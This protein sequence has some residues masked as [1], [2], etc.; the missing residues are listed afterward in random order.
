MPTPKKPAKKPAA[1]AKKPTTAKKAAPAKKPAAPARKTAASARK[2][3]PPKRSHHK[4]PAAPAAVPAPAQPPKRSH[5]KKPAPEPAP[6]WQPPKRSHHKKPVPP[7]E[8]PRA[9]EPDPYAAFD[10]DFGFPSAP[11]QPTKRS[12]HKKPV[13][14]PA[15]PGRKS[16]DELADYLGDDAPRDDPAYFAQLEEAKQRAIEPAG[17]TAGDLSAQEVSEIERDANEMDLDKLL[18]EVEPRRAE[19][20]EGLG[21]DDED[22]GAG[23]GNIAAS[24]AGALFGG[25]SDATEGEGDEEEGANRR[26]HEDRAVLLR[27]IFKRAEKGFVTNDDINEVLPPDIHKDGDIEAFIADIQAAG[28]EIADSAEGADHAKPAGADAA[29][30]AAAAAKPARADSFDDPIRMYLHQMGQTPLLTRDQ[31]VDICKRIEKSEKTVR[32]L[33]N[34][35]GFAPG[36]YY[37]VVEQIELG[38]E[39]FDRIVTDKY[40]D[41]R[42]NYLKKL[43]ELKAA[44]KAR[45]EAL[46]RVNAEFA[47]SGLGRRMVEAIL[48]AKGAKSAEQAQIARQ[49]APYVR[50]FNQHY[51][52]FLNIVIELSF[53]QKE[54][55]AL[56]GVAAGSASDDIMPQLATTREDEHFAN[57]RFHNG[58]LHRILEETKGRTGNKRVRQAI[59]Q[60]LA[61]IEAVH[62]RCLTPVDFTEEAL[63]FLREP[64]RAAR[65]GMPFEEFVR[66]SMN[67]VLRSKFATLRAALHEGHAARTEMVEANLRLVISIVK[68]YMN[69]GLS[70]LDL[71]QEG[72]TG[73]MKAVEKFE[74]RRGYKFS[75]YA[76]WWIRQAAT[77][78]IADQARTIRIPV[79]MI[80]TINRFMRTQKK[81]VQELGREP[82]ADEIAREMG[83][84]PDRVRSIL[85]MSQQPISLQSPVGDGD[86]AHFG[87]FLPDTTAEN[88]AEMTAKD[89]LRDQIH[90]V[91]QTLTDRE[92]EV[93]DFR[94]GLTDGFSRTLEEV[95]KQ[96]N[97]TRERIRQIEAKALR[98]L[99]HPTRLRRL[100]GFIND[101]TAV[102]APVAL[103][104]APPR[105]AAPASSEEKRGLVVA[106]LKKAI[107]GAKPSPA[108]REALRWHFGVEDGKLHA[109]EDTAA[110]FKLDPDS[111][112][113]QT[114]KVLKQLGR[115]NSPEL[116]ALLASFGRD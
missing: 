97:V 40:V 24:D 4:K 33:F 91:L 101:E 6:V 100:Q 74:Y 32:E 30:A 114:D 13:G 36:L 12:H 19:E 27:E 62:R 79:H 103:P 22:G 58:Q 80:E 44:L 23:F 88:P 66:A 90:S 78:A 38:T 50:R 42:F 11:A 116:R 14:P 106:E 5:H 29:A 17:P 107:S 41:S 26:R 92:R 70:F 31:E 60:E 65:K 57:W 8:P 2:P 20:D 68:K 110:R 85:K 105:A 83:I 48:R 51:H 3:E 18:N 111:L 67:D 81:L 28:I 35:F 72:N 73:L 15:R 99:R 37:K 59:Q 9:P 113:V 52:Q 75:T 71:I 21:G 98:K 55:E 84:S 64:Q 96:F 89:L 43:P 54:I 61:A 109:L 76:T 46:G 1:S 63:A 49:I 112:R 115:S 104:S 87:D 10:F 108:L 102:L 86:D 69:R 56:A 45:A 95:G 53:K 82:D 34:R 16:R 93:L 94:F 25:Y 39:R 47:E 7:P 77:R